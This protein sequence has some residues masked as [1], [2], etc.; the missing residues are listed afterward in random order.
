MPVMVRPC[1]PKERTMGET[2]QVGIADASFEIA[3]ERYRMALDALARTGQEES[4]QTP[5]WNGIAAP[6]VIWTTT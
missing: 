2:M 4:R 6:R 5:I 3:L 1:S